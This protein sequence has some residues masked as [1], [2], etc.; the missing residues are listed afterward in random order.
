MPVFV[1]RGAH[2]AADG[3]IGPTLF[4]EAI[5]ADNPADA[6]RLANTQDLSTK[7]ERANAL[8]LVDAQGI[9]HWSLRRAD[10]D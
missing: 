8:W 7:D 1:F 5:T 4:E 10:R 6:V 2:R 9:L 3:Q